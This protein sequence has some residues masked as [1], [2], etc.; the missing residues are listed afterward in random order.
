MKYTGIQSKKFNSVPTEVAKTSFIMTW[1]ELMS[2]ENTCHW[3]K[4]G[5]R[6]RKKGRSVF[7][8]TSPSSTCDLEHI[9]GRKTLFSEFHNWNCAEKQR[10][11]K[12]KLNNTLY[13]GKLLM[14]TTV[15]KLW[16]TVSVSHNFLFKI[17][18]LY[19]DIGWNKVTNGKIKVPKLTWLRDIYGWN[20]RVK[21]CIDWYHRL[22][23]NPSV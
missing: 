12:R 6:S 1:S 19:I 5:W 16:S 4:P 22:L 14:K 10:S 21:F 18:V 8:S 11:R 23:I 15:G 3:Q 13:S 9:Y 7:D 17:Q 20:R 2:R